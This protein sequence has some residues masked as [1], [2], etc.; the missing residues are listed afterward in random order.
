MTNLSHIELIELMIDFN[1]DFLID[2]HESLKER[3][4]HAGL[5]Q[6][7]NSPDFI[8]TIF[9]HFKF[10]YEDDSTNDEDEID[11]FVI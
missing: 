9:D 8:H 5:M 1:L 4:F 6:K 2:V 11:E 10:D 3:Y 7:S